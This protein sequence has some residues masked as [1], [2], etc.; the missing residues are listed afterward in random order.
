[1]K[2]TLM[3]IRFVSLVASIAFAEPIRIATEEYNLP[4]K[5]LRKRP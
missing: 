3:E 5:N 2:C 4:S 1:M